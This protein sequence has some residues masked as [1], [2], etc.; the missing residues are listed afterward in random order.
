MSTSENSTQGEVSDYLRSNWK[1]LTQGLPEVSNAFFLELTILYNSAGRHYHT[2]NHIEALLKLAE[3]H[4]HLLKSPRTIFWVI[5]YHD[6]I[7]DAAKSDNEEKS[8]D[9]ARDHLTKL[10]LD[11]DLIEECFQLIIAT[12]THTLT[13]NLSTFDAE[14]LLDIDLSILAVKQE[15][16]LEYTK[17]IRKEYKIYPD[18]LYKKGRKKVLKHFLEM[19]KIYKTELFQN[20]WEENARTNL[21]FELSEL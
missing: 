4:Q 3:E 16:Y 9:L 21:K 7:Y 6:A 13:E 15:S 8:A 1:E 14:F 10:G 17:Q 11:N 20:L 2:L 12:K 19:D 5:W 18:F